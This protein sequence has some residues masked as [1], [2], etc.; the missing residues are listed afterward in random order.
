M[1]IRKLVKDGLK[2]VDRHLPAILSI[3]AL[4]GLGGAVG[5]AIKETPKALKAIEDA[6]LEKA[7][8]EG[9]ANE[10]GE[11]DEETVKNVKLTI[12]EDFKVLA[13]VYWP[14]AL[15]T[16]STGACIVLS[17]RVSARRYAAVLAA[18]GLR[19][20]D[21]QKLK[22]KTREVLGEKKAEQV[23]EEVVKEEL[24]SLPAMNSNIIQTKYGQTLFYEPISKTPFY[25]SNTA[26]KRG[27]NEFRENLRVDGEA[28][29]NDLLSS[30][31]ID[32]DDSIDF[33]VN[34]GIKDGF[35][36]EH[37]QWQFDPYDNNQNLVLMEI[38]YT[39]D[40]MTGEP[41]G[42]LSYSQ[43]PKFVN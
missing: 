43:K 26:V 34:T 7:K 10:Y 42:V 28:S 25:S 17:Y 37:I 33:H 24:V 15:I 36:D 14:C 11:I 4:C 32:R 18:L 20:K 6:K 27:W 3:A 29:L 21:L 40:P 31:G 1:N 30:L 8:K 35:V 39:A 38:K 12:W 5:S 9:L 41:V 13:P 2:L 16:L 22:D 23:E 19:E